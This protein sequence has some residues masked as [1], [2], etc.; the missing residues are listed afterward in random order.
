MLRDGL[1]FFFGLA[2][3]VL[4]H[5]MDGPF[6][7]E[8]SGQLGNFFIEFGLLGVEFVFVVRQGAVFF[9]RGFQSAQPV[10]FDA[11]FL[12]VFEG[13]AAVFVEQIDARAGVHQSGDGCGIFHGVHQGRAAFRIL[14][15]DVGAGV[16]QRAQ[17]VFIAV[18]P[19]GPHQRRQA[20]DGGVG[21]AAGL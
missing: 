11:G 10:G 16:D 13:A 5:L 17:H 14:G 6:F 18:V 1:G 12:G 19:G 2:G 15:V 3:G 8:L 7:F 9:D 4:R 20:V 21:I